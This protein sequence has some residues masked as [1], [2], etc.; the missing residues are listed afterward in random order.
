MEHQL[1]GQVREVLLWK[2]YLGQSLKEVKELAIGKAGGR[3]NSAGKTLEAGSSLAIW[4]KEPG[5]ARA[6]GEWRRGGRW[7]GEL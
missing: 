1:H 3:E 2:G 4:R 5:V 7:D 6:E